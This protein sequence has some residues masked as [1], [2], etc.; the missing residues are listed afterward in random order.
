ML[1]QQYDQYGL[2]INGGFVQGNG[3]DSIVIDPATEQALGTIKTADDLQV[4]QVI[5][6]GVVALKAWQQLSTWERA[7]KIRKI[8]EVLQENGDEIARIISLE[9]GKPL[10][11]AAREIALSYDQFVWY[12]EQTKRIKGEI[13]ESRLPNTKSYIEY[14][15]VGV[16]AAFASWNFPLLLM[17]RKLAPA[18]AAGCPMIVRST[19]LAPLTAMK[20]MECCHQA[21]LLAGMV[22]LL[23]GKA[24]C[25]TPIIMAS[26][27]VRKISLT[28]STDVGKLLIEQSAP[29]IK[30]VTMELGGHGPVIVHED[31][32]AEAVAKL[33]CMVKFA[34]SGQ[35]CVS[36][37]RFFVHE[38]VMQTFCDTMVAEAEKLVLGNGLDE[39][40]TMGPLIHERRRQ[41]IEEFID[42]VN[43]RGGTIL[44][45]GKRP[46]GFDKGYF[47]EPT[48][49]RDLPAISRVMCEEI[50]GPLALINSFSDYDDVIERANNTEYALAAYTFT[51]S[52]AL[53]ERTRRDLVTGMVGVNTFALAA[54]EVPFGGIHY[55]G[56]G[57][58]S[59]EV[60]MQEYLNS[61]ITTVQSE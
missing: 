10:A 41:A 30:K 59:G 19:E 47:Y 15:P 18:L 29:T 55:S 3:E 17:V 37:T 39:T 36:P 35:V 6:A 14:E 2:Y 50:F 61:K 58:E 49:I 1:Q 31:A 21:D 40:T 23:C 16:C 4:S 53:A 42:N 56:I 24:S 60:G 20:L 38:N 22:A 43:T 12:A 27:Q 51:K 8:G 46:D 45:G 54:A 34:N 5:D 11:Q 32:D 44:T 25:I 13:I 52:L 7:D 48:I 26:P 28:G 9:T 57:K 33:A